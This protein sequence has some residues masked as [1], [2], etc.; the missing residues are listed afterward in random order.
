METLD[1]ITRARAGDHEAF[2]DLVGA[3]T[4]ELQ[5]HCYCI[6]GS[7]QDAEDA[8]Q[9]TLMAAWRNL[10]GFDERSSLL[11]WMY[12]IATNRCLSMLRADSR[13]PRTAVPLPNALPEPSGSSEVPAWLQPYPDVLLGE[14]ADQEPGPEARYEMT[15]AISLA[16]IVALQL[17]PPRQRAV[18]MLRD[19][20]GY[21]ALEVADML[22]T[23]QHAVHS[24]LKRA[25]ATVDAHLAQSRGGARAQRPNTAA[26]NRI[27]ARLTDAFTRGDVQA[28]IS[29]LT[30]DV[31]LSMPPAMLEFRGVAAAGRFFSAVT[32]RPGR[33]Y[34]LVPTRANRQPAFGV[35]TR[36]RHTGAWRA[37]G[38]LVIAIGGE[39]ITTV[40]GFDISVMAGFGLPRTLPE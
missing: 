32:F 36:D 37:Y 18:L 16:F 38:L 10:G 5:V 3:H 6:L 7:L 34:R 14:L 12:R 15:E 27:V 19:V 23:T 33:S 24:A 8:L 2:R 31:R 25:R 4:R 13:R 35:Y 17:L 30:D 1:L 11:T 9:E 39:K 20:L 22:D 40:T 26:E 29:L 21:P 28:L